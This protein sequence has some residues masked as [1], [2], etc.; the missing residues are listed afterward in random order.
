MSHA[1]EI[2]IGKFTIRK[3]DNQDG[4]PC[5]F[6]LH[7]C[8]EGVGIPENNL[9]EWLESYFYDDLFDSEIDEN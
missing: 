2:T 6:L 9:S 1:T 7:E 3:Y 5:V 8:G 4:E